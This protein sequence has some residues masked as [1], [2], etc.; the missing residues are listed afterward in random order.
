MLLLL[1]AMIPFFVVAF[2]IWYALFRAGSSL[3]DFLVPL[4][5]RG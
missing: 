2:A 5:S 4:L 3:A 1:A